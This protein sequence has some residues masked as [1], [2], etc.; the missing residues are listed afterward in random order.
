MTDNNKTNKQLNSYMAL[1]CM[2]WNHIPILRRKNSNALPSLYDR[3]IVKWIVKLHSHL[4]YTKFVWRFVLAKSKYGTSNDFTI[5]W[6]KVQY[7]FCH[8]AHIYEW[9]FAV[10]IF[11]NEKPKI[12]RMNGSSLCTFSLLNYLNFTYKHINES[13]PVY[14]TK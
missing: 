1:H 10:C 3:K 8:F 2:K 6:V 13:H 7:C 5:V 4:H 12:F 14:T 9:K 11:L